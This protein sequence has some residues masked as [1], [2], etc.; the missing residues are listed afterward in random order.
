MEF[1]VKRR[2]IAGFV[3]VFMIL[4]VFT[5]CNT[6][7]VT[8]TETDGVTVATE[9]VTTNAAVTTTSAVTT[10]PIPELDLPLVIQNNT[11]SEDYYIDINGNVKA[12][13]KDDILMTNVRSIYY[14][15]GINE[16]NTYFFIKNDNTLWGFGK[17][18]HGFLGETSDID[19]INEAIKL[20]IENVANVYANP[21]EYSNNTIYVVTTEKELY[22]WGDGSDNG[23]ADPNMMRSFT[24][25]KIADDVIRFI[26]DNSAITST[27]FLISW[28][29]DIPQVQENNYKLTRLLYNVVDAVF[30]LTIDFDIIAGDGKLYSYNYSYVDEKYEITQYSFFKTANLG[31]CKIY[32]FPFA[33]TYYLAQDSSLYGVNPNVRDYELI[34]IADSVE[35][36]FQADFLNEN[37]SY[38]AMFYDKSNNLYEI[39]GFRTGAN[40][41]MEN[42]AYIYDKYSDTYTLKTDG[43][44]VR[45]NGSVYAT[46]VALPGIMGEETVATGATTEPTTTP[47]T[48]EATPA[49]TEPSTPSA[50]IEKTVLNVYSF[51]DE[52]PNMFKK[53]FEVYPDRA[54]LYDINTTIIATTDGAYE[55]ALDQALKGGAVTAPDLFCAESA[56]I[57]KYTKGSMSSYVAP[58]DTLGIDVDGLITKGDIAQYSIDVGSNSAGD[59]VGLGYESTAGAFIY[60]SSI[61]IDTWGTDDP[62]T[63]AGKIGPGWDK[64]LSAAA[65][66]KAK[67]YGIVSGGGDVWHAFENSDSTG[68]IVNGK[69]TISPERLGFFDISKKLIDNNYHNNAMEWSDAWY[70]DMKG[71]GKKPVFGFFGPAW[72]ASWIMAPNCGG[73]QPGQGTYGDWRVCEPPSGFYWGGTW[74]LTSKDSQNK[75]AIGDFIEW[76]T[77]DSSNTGLQYFWA[78]GLSGMNSGAKDAVTSS[79][80]MGK[81][82]GS[83]DFLGG[84]NMFDVY[85]SANDS[86]NGKTVSEYDLKINSYFRN[87]VNYYTSGETD[88]ETA[89][90]WFKQKVSDDLGIAV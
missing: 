4:G 75:E 89:I 5:G 41:Y 66:L 37:Y 47:E 23:L 29:T 38:S 32:D 10:A 56:F 63:I 65:D 40:L 80:V 28:N 62:N 9:R 72:F 49:S 6:V 35:S 7:E 68:W 24:P 46:N 14:F 50:R 78:N 2:F 53:Y 16:D 67:G 81:S 76:V 48:P 52:V 61:A 17:N 74:L 90:A 84:Q 51:T 12:F 34:K 87:A 43:T 39:N 21:Q 88:K 71:V 1:V 85:I 69:L 64:F 44:I 54:K 73:T 27:G 30:T 8:N 25:V 13:G 36:V 42:V 26:G 82:N 83:Y 58:Y 59:V 33:G 18:Y 86:A 19:D 31:L 77:L 57:Y 79:T 70:D 20:P 45:E 22:G 55:P 60:R 3:L 11:V 15:D